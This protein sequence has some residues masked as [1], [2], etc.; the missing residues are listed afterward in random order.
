MKRPL[1]TLAG[2]VGVAAVLAASCTSPNRGAAPKPSPSGPP[3]VYV[4]VGASESVGLGSSDPIRNGWTQLFYRDTL[5]RS[6]VFVNMAES[7]STLAESLTNQLPEAV[8]LGPDVVTVWLNVNDIVH[9]VPASTYEQ[10]LRTLVSSLRRGGKAKVLLANTPPLDHLPAYLA[11]LSGDPQVSARCVTPAVPDVASV[12]AAVDDY[13]AATARV[14]A[15][16]GAILVDL[17]A[18]GLAARQAGIEASLVA[19]DGFHPSDAGHAFVAREFAA[20]YRR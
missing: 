3:L 18:A 4:A 13:N 16:T 7:G 8:T 14:A 19:S 1:G 2:L 5:P 6:T 17:H 10:E 15:A 11:C 20:A 12:D 9:A